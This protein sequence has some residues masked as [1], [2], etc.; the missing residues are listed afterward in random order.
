[1]T[2]LKTAGGHHEPNIQ[3]RGLKLKVVSKV[4][5]VTFPL[6]MKNGYSETKNEVVS[7]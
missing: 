6:L 5:A 4:N 7:M 1:M 3:S 2:H